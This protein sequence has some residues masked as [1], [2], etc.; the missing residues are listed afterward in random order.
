MKRCREIY[1]NQLVLRMACGTETILILKEDRTQLIR[2]PV[3]VLLTPLKTERERELPDDQF[4]KADGIE[5]ANFLARTA[6]EEGVSPTWSHT[7]I[8]L[9][10]L[11]K[12]Q[13][14]QLG[15]T[16]SSSPWYFQKFHSGIC[17]EQG[18]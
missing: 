15:R 7:F 3:F 13:L 8:E 10:S 1:P 5:K 6:A 16:L 11:M 12:I 4:S 17:L 14:N 18:W 9:S 2:Y